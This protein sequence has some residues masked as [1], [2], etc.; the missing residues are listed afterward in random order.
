MTVYGFRGYPSDAQLLTLQQILNGEPPANSEPVRV[1]TAPGKAFNYSG[2]GY[3]LVQQLV[4]DVT[5]RSFAGLAQELIYDKL[6]MTNST[7]EYLL[8]KAYVPQAATAT[9][10]TVILFPENGTLTPNRHRPVC[11]APRRIWR[12]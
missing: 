7:F 5:V 10:I 8:P 4:E 12:A 11:G 1:M 9:S 6:G 3:V 2:G